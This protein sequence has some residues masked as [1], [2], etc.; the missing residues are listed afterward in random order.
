[1]MIYHY[2]NHYHIMLK[3]MRCDTRVLCVMTCHDVT[4]RSSMTWCVVRG[5]SLVLMDGLTNKVTTD[6]NGVD[7]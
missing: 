5:N 7:L 1:M 3:T 2:S 4:S 6:Y